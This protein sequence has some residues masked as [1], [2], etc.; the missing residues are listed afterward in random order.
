L[1]A[2]GAR[3]HDAGLVGRLRVERFHAPWAEVSADTA[4]GRVRFV[5]SGLDVRT[6]GRASL[7]RVAEDAGLNP[8]HGCRMG[9]CHS[10]D[11]RLLSG[12]VRDLRSGT[13]SDEPGHTVQICI[14]AAAGDVAL[15][16]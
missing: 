2:V 7:L 13:V 16:L 6:D 1:A 5:K 10:C 15:D 9:I 8:P 3:W 14:S 12:C 4:G 11:A